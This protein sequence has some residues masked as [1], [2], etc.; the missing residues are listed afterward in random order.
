MTE[1]VVEVF[2]GKDGVDILL[3]VM[4]HQET[5]LELSALA[6]HYFLHIAADH[7]EYLN[8]ATKLMFEDEII[9]S[10]LNHELTKELLVETYHW[11]EHLRLSTS[12]QSRALVLTS[13]CYFL[14]AVL[15]FSR[16]SLSRF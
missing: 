15:K 13:A 10:L 16:I 4:K 6:L 5:E 12:C 7:A 9:P 2:D 3:D 11:Y 8:D 14:L 1:N